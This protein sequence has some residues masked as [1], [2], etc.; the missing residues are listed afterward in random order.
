MKKDH[1]MKRT[2]V[3]I[4]VAAL[5]GAT[6]YLIDRPP[7]KTTVAQ[8]M[9]RAAPPSLMAA[10]SND[11]SAVA[12]EA[13][14]PSSAPRPTRL[15]PPTGDAEFARLA[16]PQ[17]THAE[18][19]KAYSMA[20][21]CMEENAPGGV[22]LP[23]GPDFPANAPRPCQLSV[24]SWNDANT[25]RRLLLE[26]V[27]DGLCFMETLRESPH[28]AYP[29]FAP[30]E[31]AALEKKALEK[32]VEVGEPFALVYKARELN[33]KAKQQTGD[34]ARATLT[35]ALTYD[36]ASAMGI[37]YLNGQPFSMK[38][39]PNLQA[40]LPLYASLPDAAGEQA[41]QTARQLVATFKKAKESTS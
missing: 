1:P 40:K 34:E 5:V 30:A 11:E 7:D 16:S 41:K 37:A 9:G 39:S 8:P 2:A 32:G 26:C 24:D 28:S 33:D 14:A 25:R 3:A 29:T 21:R 19:R 6:A 15:P 22:R 4:A 12:Q 38:Q 17:A 27:D 35:Q 31:F 13:S 10:A 20:L 18:H 23:W 36:V